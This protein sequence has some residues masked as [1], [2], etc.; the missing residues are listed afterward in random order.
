MLQCDKCDSSLTVETVLENCSGSWPEQRWL[1]FVCPSCNLSMKA[2]VNSGRMAIGDID[3]APGPSFVE[4]SSIDSQK[5][6]VQKT[7]RGLKCTWGERVFIFE[8]IK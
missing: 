4:S 6:K 3:G 8:P 1:A 7:A 2:H 5:L